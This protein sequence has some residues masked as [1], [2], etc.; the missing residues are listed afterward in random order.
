MNPLAYI[1]PKSVSDARREA[2]LTGSRYFAGGIDLLGELKDDLLP[3]DRLVNVKGLPGLSGIEESGTSWRIGANT[4]VAAIAGHAGLAGAVPGLAEAAGHVGSPQI[5]NRATLGGNL[6]QHSRCWYYRHRDVSCLKNGGSTC[7]A[8]E[9]ESKYHSLFT[10]NTCIS[11]VVSNLA[12]ALAA[13]DATVRVHTRDGEQAWSIDRLYE[14]AWDNP[15]AHNALRS[16]DLILG[17]DIPRAPASRRSAYRQLSEKAEF[18]W[19]LVSCSVALDVVGGRIQSPRIVFGALSPVPHR[20]TE[21]ETLL[22]GAE[23][24]P[25]LFAQAAEAALAGAE[26]TPHNQYKV[27]QAQ[28]LLRRILADLT[29]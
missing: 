18:D 23:P 3:V 28:T 4:P 27:P 16:D 25:A 12:V 11:P 20:A 17:V 19:A 2:G 5:R 29:A 21:A 14:D 24:A 1:Q 6:A 9:G 8:R 15:T 26:P 7:Y 13:L 22:A 10:G